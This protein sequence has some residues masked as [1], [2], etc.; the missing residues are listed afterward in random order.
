MPFDKFAMVN[1]K[2]KTNIFNYLYLFIF[3]H[4]IEVKIHFVN[5]I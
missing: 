3:K 5:T 1:F 4:C 2:R